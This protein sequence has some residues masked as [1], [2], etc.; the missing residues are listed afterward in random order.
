MN[1]N[2]EHTN[3]NN[4]S[5]SKEMNHQLCDDSDPASYF[6]GNRKL[7]EAQAHASFMNQTPNVLNDQ[8]KFINEVTK[9]PDLSKGQPINNDMMSM[10][11]SEPQTNNKKINIPIATASMCSEYIPVINH[12]NNKDN[13]DDDNSSNSTKL[14]DLLVSSL[15]G[16]VLATL[17]LSEILAKM[18]S[19]SGEMF[20][21]SN[22]NDHTNYQ[23]CE[24]QNH[25]N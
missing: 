23:F 10:L 12:I 13:D 20:D 9:M 22:C 25:V 15:N 16:S 5:M 14:I 8:K 1:Q 18:K 6:L 2:K 21:T 4:E 19:T 24:L 11:Q 7:S 3:E 17:E